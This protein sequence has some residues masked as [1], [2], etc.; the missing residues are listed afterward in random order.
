MVVKRRRGKIPM[1]RGDILEAKFVGAIGAIAQTRFLHE[2]LHDAS[3][4]RRTTPCPHSAWHH[5]AP[6][7]SPRPYSGDRTRCQGGRYLESLQP[8]LLRLTSKQT[9]CL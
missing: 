9:L 2:D 3:G 6:P 1:D 4:D 8:R 7:P 5:N